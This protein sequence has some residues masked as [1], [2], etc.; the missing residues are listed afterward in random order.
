MKIFD[1]IKKCDGKSKSASEQGEWFKYFKKEKDETQNQLL[2][3]KN[4]ES[5]LNQEVYKIFD[6]TE[7]EIESVETTTPE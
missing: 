3:I 6:L 2:I 1:E 7:D 4:L 5:E